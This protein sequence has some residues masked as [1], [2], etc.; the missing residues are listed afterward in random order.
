MRRIL[1]ATALGELSADLTTAADETLIATGLGAGDAE[2]AVAEEIAEPE[3][4]VVPE[5]IPVAEEIAVSREAD[6]IGEAAAQHFEPPEEEH[7]MDQETRIL[8]PIP[9]EGEIRIT[10]TPWLD[11]VEVARQHP[12]LPR[13]RGRRPAPRADRHPPRPPPLPGARGRRLGGPRAEVRP[14]RARQLG[15]RPPG[16]LDPLLAVGEQVAVDLGQAGEVVDVL[17][18]VGDADHALRP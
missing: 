16:D 4:I 3:E 10:A 1:R 17:V 7:H 6:R 9:D 13:D 18:Q 14:L 2:I 8:E 5:E 15:A 11:E 12:R